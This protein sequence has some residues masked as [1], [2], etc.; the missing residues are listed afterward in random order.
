MLGKS[1]NAIDQAQFRAVTRLRQI[2]R[3]NFP[4]LE[5]ER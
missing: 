3:E 2:A 5:V 1:G 4:E